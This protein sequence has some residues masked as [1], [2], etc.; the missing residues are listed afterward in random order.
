MARDY[1]KTKALQLA[2]LNCCIRFIMELKYLDANRYEELW[3]KSEE[4]LKTPQGLISY[5]EKS[6]V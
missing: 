6:G 5:A 2:E 4:G 1:R 3:A